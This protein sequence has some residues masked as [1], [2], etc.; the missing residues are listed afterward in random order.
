MYSM[1]W[2]IHALHQA[3]SCQPGH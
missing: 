3:C 2:L 1:V